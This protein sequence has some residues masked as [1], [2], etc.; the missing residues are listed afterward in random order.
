MND[1]EMKLKEL[2]IARYGNLKKFCD[3]IDMPWT[4]L[5]SILKRGVEKANIANVI[6]I[7]KELGIDTESLADGLIVIRRSHTEDHDKESELLSNYRKLND[8][9]KNKARGDVSDLTQIP[10]YT[11]KI[12]PIRKEEVYLDAA[13]KRPGAT[14]EDEANDDS[15]MDDEK[16]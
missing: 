4:T 5:D 11:S 13:H 9:G 3:V 16:F 1:I 8:M 14:P 2:I 7:A 6:K 10:K 12:V 15:I